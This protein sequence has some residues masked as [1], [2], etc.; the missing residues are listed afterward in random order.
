MR[1][2]SCEENCPLVILH[3]DDDTDPEVLE[4]AGQQRVRT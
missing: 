3:H 2:A 4:A 1:G